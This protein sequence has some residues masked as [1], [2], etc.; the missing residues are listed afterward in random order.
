MNFEH[1][2]NHKCSNCGKSVEII[3]AKIGIYQEQSLDCPYCFNLLR[4]VK[5][6]KKYHYIKRQP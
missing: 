1:R 4:N 5:P 3:K 6:S 2:Y